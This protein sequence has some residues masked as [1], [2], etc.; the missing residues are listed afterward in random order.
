M[1]FNLF[2]LSITKRQER[3]LLV[4]QRYPE[5]KK[6]VALARL[7][8]QLGHVSSHILFVALGGSFYWRLD[9]VVY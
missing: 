7:E 4:V 8:V 1:F 2:S 5:R 9:D 3:R 6:H